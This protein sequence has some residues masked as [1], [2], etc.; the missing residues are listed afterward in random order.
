MVQLLVW[1]TSLAVVCCS[2]DDP[3][4]TPPHPSFSTFTLAFTNFSPLFRTREVFF[5]RNGSHLGM[6]FKINSAS[7]AAAAYS[8][9]TLIAGG[10]AAGAAAAAAAA[11]SRRLSFYPT[12]GLHAKH[13]EVSVNF[14]ASP[15]TFDIQ[16]FEEDV[17]A[18]FEAAVSSMVL[19][20]LP[21]INMVRQHLA[22]SG[23]H[24]SLQALDNQVLQLASQ[25][26]SVRQLL[27]FLLGQ[28]L[29]HF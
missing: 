26:P 15:F 1:V 12:I 10:V 6:A 3:A 27:T 18:E 9:T 13:E 11:E 20:P 21:L 19:P 17:L 5:T 22:F 8:A 16:S 28:W 7:A 23:M 2:G 14:G 4:P 25:T 29:D 24:A